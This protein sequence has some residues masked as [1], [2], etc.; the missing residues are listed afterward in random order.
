MFCPFPLPKLP[1]LPEGRGKRALAFIF[2]Y[3][4]ALAAAFGAAKAL[5]SYSLNSL[6]AV[7][8]GDSAILSL[9]AID[10]GKLENIVKIAA[11]DKKVAALLGKAKSSRRLSYV[12][13]AE[14]YAAEVPMNGL[15][16]RAG[17][18]SPA[19]YDDR[20]YKVIFTAVRCYGNPAG[21]EMFTKIREREPL[22]EVWV[23]A[24]EARVTRVLDIPNNYKYRGIP[25]A[26]Y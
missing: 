9:A 4:F 14:W 1:Q 20:Q 3:I 24:A 8:S 21:P 22:A 6:Y 2:I 23:N 16:R 11:A 5:N 7:Y 13:P 19:G 10:E 18:L 26:V 15:A 17:H 12:L 25:V